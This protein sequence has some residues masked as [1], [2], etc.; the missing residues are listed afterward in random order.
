MENGDYGACAKEY[1]TRPPSTS[2]VVPPPSVSISSGIQDSDLNS[3]TDSK[4]DKGLAGWAIALV[5]IFV[6]SFVCCVGYAIAIVGFDVTKLFD[7]FFRDHDDAKVIHRN[8]YL[9]KR[10][11]RD[12]NCDD[13]SQV[14]RRG[15]KMLAI[16]DG[17]RAPGPA[18]W[19]SENSRAIVLATPE[20]RP[21]FDESFTIDS[22]NST[23][24]KISRDPTLYIPGREDKPDP[25]CESGWYDGGNSREYYDDPPLKLKREPTMYVDGISYNGELPSK[26]GRDPTMYID[27]NREADIYTIDESTVE[28]VHNDYNCSIEHY[29]MIV[30]RDP[31][32][33]DMAGSESTFYDDAVQRFHESRSIKSARSKESIRSKKSGKGGSV[34]TS[35]KSTKGISTR[36]LKSPQNDD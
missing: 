29:G 34:D 27:G 3:K 18:S 23:K 14:S 19:R 13:R 36:M 35:K 30:N 15:R 28:E 22:H 16:E 17:S 31:T 20:D 10:S 5:I 26:L 32:Y 4:D 9:D 12:R 8:A 2:V 7:D 11:R 6:L 33:Y 25:F 1:P 21:L 24:Y